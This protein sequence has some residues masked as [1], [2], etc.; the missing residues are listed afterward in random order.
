VP[1]ATSG[2]ATLVGLVV[3]DTI[4][5][6]NQ[7]YDSFLSNGLCEEP[8]KIT[9]PGSFSISEPFVCNNITVEFRDG[10]GTLVGFTSDLSLTAAANTDTI[11]RAKKMS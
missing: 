2:T 6:F 7:Y 9:T 8:G 4:I 11:T 5:D 10:V 3:G 1:P